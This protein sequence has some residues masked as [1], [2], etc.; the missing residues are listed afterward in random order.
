MPTYAEVAVLLPV[1]KTFT[2]A[3]PEHLRDRIRI[4]SCVTVLF[5]SRRVQGFVLGL[6]PEHGMS[7]DKNIREVVRV[8]GEIPAFPPGLLPLYQWTSRYYLS[9]LGEVL[10][11]GLPLPPVRPP[12]SSV[13]MDTLPSAKGKNQNSRPDPIL[14]WSSVQQ[15]YKVYTDILD[16]TLR[17]GRTGLVLFPT[18]AQCRHWSGELQKTWGDRV[19]LIHDGLARGRLWKEWVRIRTGEAKIVV[20]PRSAVFAPLEDP[21]VIIVDEE[22]DGAY[23]E[24]KR[25]GYNARDIGLLRG[26]MCGAR[27]VLGS[28]VPSVETFW[29]ARQGR[30]ARTAVPPQP[31]PP[32]EVVDMRGTKGVYLS[33]P[34]KDALLRAWGAR[35]RGPCILFVHRRGFAPSLFCHDCGHVFRC[36]SCGLSLAYHSHEKTLRCHSCNSASPVGTTCP[37]CGGS[38]F[39]SF[40]AGTQRIEKEVRDLLPG[41]RVVRVDRDTPAVSGSMGDLSMADVVVGTHMTAGIEMPRA[42]F[43]GMISADP[44][45]NLPHYRAS[46]RALHLMVHLALKGERLLIQS[47]APGHHVLTALAGRDLEIFYSHELAL[48]KDLAYPPFTRLLVV[49]V[50]SAD[51]RRAAGI[52]RDI[53]RRA[54]RAYGASS[55]RVLGPAPDPAEMHTGC[56]VRQIF[57]KGPSSP[58]LHS[59]AREAL[60][61]G[62]REGKGVKIRVDFDP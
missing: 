13:P 16:A 24:E 36:E 50:S 39:G 43:V 44:L 62:R 6:R 26:N 53:V 52:S 32:V 4:G 54:L 46:E 41:A 35:G 9:S 42:Q 23:R 29:R 31:L 49:R 60:S 17:S 30:Y 18:I 55:L 37:D 14:V 33:P 15:R 19:S 61:A 25:P 47:F 21:G 10:R 1:E 48:R 38:R 8:R 51:D 58:A 20:G 11:A 2:Y 12:P 45:L 27:V 5:G 57:I 40:G 59:A 56:H 3:I 22:Q 28:T 34:M 7:R